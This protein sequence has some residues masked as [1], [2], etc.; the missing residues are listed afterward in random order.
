MLQISVQMLV[1][2]LAQVAKEAKRVV[3]R[4]DAAE[5]Q[6]QHAH[7]ADPQSQ[8][9]AELY[10]LGDKARHHF[11]MAHNLAMQTTDCLKAHY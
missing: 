7:S 10:S 5:Q 9:L 3:A 6:S 2:L 1:T 4:L 8:K 11:Y